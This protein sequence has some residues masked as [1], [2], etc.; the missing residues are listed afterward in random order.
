MAYI[1][2]IKERTVLYMKKVLVLLMLVLMVCG[3]GVTQQATDGSD[4]SRGSDGQDGRDYVT[5][6][7]RPHSF[8]PDGKTVMFDDISTAT[9]PMLAT[10]GFGTYAEGNFMSIKVPSGNAGKKVCV[11]I[12]GT[13]SATVTIPDNNMNYA[14]FDTNAGLS[15]AL[16]IRMNSSRIDRDDNNS[17]IAWY[18][19]GIQQEFYFSDTFKQ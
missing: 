9:K 13:L 18:F 7:I 16:T 6:L 8:S 12:N 1:T 2:I 15:D 17:Y 10:I 19:E 5:P 4:G 14:V 3:C 11:I